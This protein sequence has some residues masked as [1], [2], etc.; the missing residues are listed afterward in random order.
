M[1]S[2]ASRTAFAASILFLVAAR[3][4]GVSDSTRSRLSLGLSFG[5]GLGYRTLAITSPS[6]VADQIAQRRNE[7]EEPSL[8]YG[9]RGSLA[10]RLNERWSLEAGLGYAQ[11]GWRSEQDYSGLTFG[12]VIDPRTGFIYNT[13]D[14]AIPARSTITDLFHYLELPLGITLNLGHG[15][16]RSISAIGLAPAVLLAAST[17]AVNEFPDGRLEEDTYDQGDPYSTFNLFPYVSTGI[18]FQAGERWELSL[19]PGVRYGA[20]R[21]I[22]STV[23]GHVFMG[24]VDLGVRIRL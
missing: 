17:R 12:D 13:T 24:T 9:V 15:R 4:H 21:I 6:T 10:Y 20:L 16:W 1:R 7:Q 2:F 11:L 5:G 22:D 8:A 19:K 23:T 3:A 14:A 18:A